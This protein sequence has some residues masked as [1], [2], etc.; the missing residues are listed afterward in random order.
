MEYF[1]TG[2]RARCA[3]KTVSG[4]L[5]LL[6]LT[7]A[8]GVISFSRAAG[9]VAPP[10]PTP[11]AATV[12][13]SIAAALKSTAVPS[14][15]TP[16]LSAFSNETAGALSG[17]SLTYACDPYGS[18][19][20]ATKPVPCLFGDLAATETIVIVGDSNVGNWVPA[21]NIGLKAAGYRLAAF[22]YAGCPAA[23]TPY[24]SIPDSQTSECNLWHKTV[25]AVI[26]ALDPVAVLVASGDD[27]PGDTTNSQW[28]A[29]FSKLYKLTT[30]NS[31]VRILMGTSPFTTVNPPSCLARAAIHKRARSTMPRARST[32]HS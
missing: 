1:Q 24:K 7:T 27:F 9:A 25:P 28:I 31:T 8:V 17:D 20:L 14:D 30:S 16:P 23:D 21:L 15:L 11:A 3:S 19:K 22:S 13:K 6:L 32:H 12:L 10:T 5:V 18:A 29:G 2:P 4:L 26:K